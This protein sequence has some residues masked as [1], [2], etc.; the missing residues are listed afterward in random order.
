VNVQTG[1]IDDKRSRSC[2]VRSEV[3]E[4]LE[5]F[6]GMRADFDIERCRLGPFKIRERAIE[7][8]GGFEPEIG[9]EEWAGYEGRAPIPTDV[10][11]C[12]KVSV[13]VPMLENP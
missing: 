5:V 2:D 6:Q 4:Y 3:L 8:W 10:R 11:G 13:A 9:P 1:A 12:G 7:I